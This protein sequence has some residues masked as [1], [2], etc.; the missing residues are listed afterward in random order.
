MLGIE[1]LYE[2]AHEVVE[3]LALSRPQAERLFPGISEVLSSID[4]PRLEKLLLT[5]LVLIHLGPQILR[6]APTQLSTRAKIFAT[7]LEILVVRS[8]LTEMEFSRKAQTWLDALSVVAW[9]FF[10]TFRGSF[11]RTL[12][13]TELEALH[14]EWE[15][16]SFA[17]ESLGQKRISEAFILL[18]H[19]GALELLLARTV[20]TPVGNESIRFRHREWE[21]YLVSRYLSFCLAAAQVS[22][23]CR[24]GFNKEI[25]IAAAEQLESGYLGRDGDWPIISAM[26]GSR[27]R[28]ITDGKQRAFGITNVTAVAGNGRV[29]LDEDGLNAIFE[30]LRQDE[31]WE[32]AKH[33]TINAMSL[34]LLRRDPDDI[35]VL[36]LKRHLVPYLE[37]VASQAVQGAAN[38]LTGSLAWC[39][40]CALGFLPAEMPPHRYVWPGERLLTGRRDDA[41]ATVCDINDSYRVSKAYESVQ[42]AY[43]S[44]PS[45]TKGRPFEGIAI[46]H[47]IFPVA[48]A[49]VK[50]LAAPQTVSILRGITREWPEIKKQILEM[51]KIPGIVELADASEKFLYASLT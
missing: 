11:A 50:G 18:R 41:L 28:A 6:F 17:E 3:V 8:K 31:C 26:L 13:R 7:A 36:T 5:P 29:S 12:L 24:R 37:E 14:R 38:V 20:F 2:T 43:A 1:E 34:R 4:D 25:Y 39:Y 44:Y 51:D 23:L 21:D 46:V 16:L 40:L 49:L 42:V 22:D 30:M 32:L 47:Y 15:K 33:V 27:L 35:W 10:A 45:G 48:E 19:P 9:L